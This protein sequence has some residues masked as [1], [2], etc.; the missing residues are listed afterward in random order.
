MRLLAPAFF[1]LAAVLVP[2]LVILYFLK[3]KRRPVLVPSTMLWRHAI[4]DIRVNAPFRWFRNNI[5]L[6]L[7]LLVLAAL[8]W[9]LVRPATNARLGGGET[10][11]LLVDNSASMGALDEPGGRLARAREEARKVI[12]GMQPDDQAMII[13]FA[14]KASIASSFS[15]NKSALVDR[16]KRIQVRQ[17][18]TELTEALKIAQGYAE[19]AARAPIVYVLSDGRVGPT[20][21]AD[22]EAAEVR[23]VRVGKAG[24]NIGITAFNASRSFTGSDTVQVFARI[25]NF[26]DNDATTVCELLNDGTIIDARETAV[27]ARDSAACLFEVRG[28]R[29]GVLAAHL[30]TLDDLAVDNTAWTVVE[31]RPPLRVLLVSAGNLF[32]ERVLEAAGRIELATVLPREFEPSENQAMD[33]SSF[34]LVIFDRFAPAAPPEPPA[35]FVGAVPGYGDLVPADEYEN[36]MVLDWDRGHPLML[37]TGFDDLRVAKALGVDRLQQSSVLLWSDRGALMFVYP[38]QELTDVVVAF[39]ILESD[40]PLRVSFPVFFDNLLRFYSE[41]SQKGAGSLRTGSIIRIPVEGAQGGLSITD[42]RGKR[43]RVAPTGEKMGLFSK[44]AVAGLYTATTA[45]GTELRYALN[46]LDAAE[47]DI[48]PVEDLQIGYKKVAG[49]PRIVRENREL[50]KLFACLALG[51]LLVEWAVFNRKIAA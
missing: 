4:E 32:L 38:R 11:I 22:L 5:L 7:Q 24:D 13:S 36:P 47:S 27:E 41:F 30:T 50:W 51:F 19:R 23:F 49:T 6:I 39:D 21:R 8:I 31:E 45:E 34:D 2:L 12:D 20:G 14:D 3:L 16:L 48:A 42:P 29:Q 43:H 33:T 9:S 25:H 1:W 15:S 26:S 18:R 35:V 46:L 37:H 28:I 17:T 40:W 10:Y 44:T